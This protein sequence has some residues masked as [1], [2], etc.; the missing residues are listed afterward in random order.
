MSTGEPR[1]PEADEAPTVPS[2]ECGM[3]ARRGRRFRRGPIRL[4]L[5]TQVFIKK[6]LRP[7]DPHDP[8]YFAVSL[9]WRRF[10][11]L[12]VASELA[13]NLVFAVLYSLQPGSVSNQ[14]AMPLLSNVYG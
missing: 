3:P 5:G 2:T 6:G 4:S 8:Y 13:I 10:G 14:G 12:F 11:A 9:S 1:A 7:F